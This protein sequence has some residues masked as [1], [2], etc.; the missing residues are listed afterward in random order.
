MELENTCQVSLSSPMKAFP[1]NSRLFLFY[2]GTLII[3]FPKLLPFIIWCP[4]GFRPLVNHHNLQNK[5]YVVSLAL[6]SRS[7]FLYI[8][9]LCFH[10]P[11]ILSC[12]KI[13]EFALLSYLPM[14]CTYYLK[15]PFIL[16]FP[17]ELLHFICFETLT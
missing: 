14:P 6:R 10:V 11:V 8:I 17:F 7:H 9:S 2:S 1:R 5:I 13:F 15:C 16:K 3:S 4:L 12:L